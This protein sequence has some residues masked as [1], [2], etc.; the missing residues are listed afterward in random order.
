M[1]LLTYK[2][3]MGVCNSEVKCIKG[4]EKSEVNRNKNK[5]Y[6]ENIVRYQSLVLFIF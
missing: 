2:K 6:S 1:F 4:M 3:V 5:L